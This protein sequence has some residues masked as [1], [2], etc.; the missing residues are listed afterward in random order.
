MNY[1]LVKLTGYHCISYLGIV[2][3]IVS[4][5]AWTEI[6]WLYAGISYTDNGG[7]VVVH[8]QVRMDIN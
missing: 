1:Y 6:G 3:P 2:Y 4:H 7:E 5:W 8:Y